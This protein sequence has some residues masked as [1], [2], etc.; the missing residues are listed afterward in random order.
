MATKNFKWKPSRARWGACQYCSQTAAF[1]ARHR[2]TFSR[3]GHVRVGFVT[4]SACEVHE[5][6]LREILAVHASRGYAVSPVERNPDCRSPS[7]KCSGDP[8]CWFD[9]SVMRCPVHGQE[10]R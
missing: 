4:H 9:V 3:C 8:G 1:R 7:H 10:A 5:P 2:Y 6:A